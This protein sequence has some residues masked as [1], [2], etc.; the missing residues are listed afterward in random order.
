MSRDTCR[1]HAGGAPEARQ[2]HIR[3]TPTA[4]N[5]RP[6]SP[7]PEPSALACCEQRPEQEGSTPSQG[8]T[9]ALPWHPRGSLKAVTR[10]AADL[11]T[12]WDARAGPV[13]DARPGRGQDVHLRDVDGDSNDGRRALAIVVAVPKDEAQEVPPC[14]P[15]HAHGDREHPQQRHGSDTHNLH[16]AWPRMGLLTAG[17]EP[18][19][20]HRHEPLSQKHRQG[21]ATLPEGGREGRGAPGVSPVSNP[22]GVLTVTSKQLTAPSWKAL[23]VE[24]MPFL[25]ANPGSGAAPWP[26]SHVV[27]HA[28]AQRRQHHQVRH[29]LEVGGG[30]TIPRLRPRVPQSQCSR[31]LPHQERG[32]GR[33][34]EP[35]EAP[36]RERG[37]QA[38]RAEWHAAR[39]WGGHRQAQGTA[40]NAWAACRARASQG[41]RHKQVTQRRQGAQEGCPD[42]GAPLGYP[43]SG[44][45]QKLT[46]HRKVPASRGGA[47][48]DPP[49]RRGRYA[50][51]QPHG[52]RRPAPSRRRP[53][54]GG[55][56]VPEGGALG[57][58]RGCCGSRGAASGGRRRSSPD[59]RR[60][61]RGQGGH[62]LGVTRGCGSGANGLQT[63]TLPSPRRPSPRPCALSR[64]PSSEAPPWTLRKCAAQAS[65]SELPSCQRFP[66]VGAPWVALRSPAAESLLSPAPLSLLPVAA[67]ALP[68]PPST[69]RRSPSLSAPNP[70]PWHHR[71]RARTCAG[72]PPWA[73]PRPLPATTHAEVCVQPLL[74]ALWGPPPATT[75]AEVCVQPLLQPCGAPPPAHGRRGCAVLTV[76]PERGAQGGLACLSRGTVPTARPPRVVLLRHH[77]ACSQQSL[78]KP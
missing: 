3:G 4:H 64:Q 77:G 57:A 63:G 24:A 48:G 38:G 68:L 54:P 52:A 32:A 56:R 1:L 65:R 28:G 70:W 40:P 8:G 67:P 43:R 17:G 10:S 61:S 5:Q 47:L 49:P 22:P 46:S 18:S 76:P 9:H 23:S 51:P 72:M 13:V 31:N 12:A 27:N 58:A 25:R 15:Q 29:P 6:S 69:Q 39:T 36:V 19:L 11:V 16:R 62:R 42:P 41:T 35:R 60:G 45:L 53:C 37:T 30:A 75:H 34:K 21:G 44:L 33:V 66:R 2:R 55:G 71:S 59:H 7:P 26:A 74:P 14:T 50:E 20:K 73:S 78:P